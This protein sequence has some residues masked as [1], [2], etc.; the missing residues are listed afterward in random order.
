MKCHVFLKLLFRILHLNFITQE[1][2]KEKKKK[3]KEKERKRRKRKCINCW[4]P[5]LGGLITFPVSGPKY[6]WDWIITASMSL[7]YTIGLYIY[8]LF[9]HWF[10]Q[11]LLST[12]DYT[13]PK[14]TKRFHGS[15]NNQKTSVHITQDLQ[16]KQKNLFSQLHFLVFFA[17]HLSVRRRKDFIGPT[18]FFKNLSYLY[19]VWHL[20]IFC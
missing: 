5:V 15:E 4:T 17:F 1:E 10:K 18:Y 14:K 9:Y 13:C 7:N 2:K 12:A 3:E 6:Y 19:I 11:K 8:T 16:V 20:D